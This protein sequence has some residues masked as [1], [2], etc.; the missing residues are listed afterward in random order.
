MTDAG[1]L[2]HVSPKNSPTGIR[3]NLV[4]KLDAAGLNL[5]KGTG[6]AGRLKKVE[7]KHDASLAEFFDALGLDTYDVDDYANAE[8][9]VFT[10]AEDSATEPD[11]VHPAAVD[12][13][14]TAAGKKAPG[15]IGRPPGSK[16]RA[17]EPKKKA[18]NK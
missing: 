2:K 7:L 10:P 11:A 6:G 3:D 18:H 17:K 9:L 12:S 14:A 16:N 1:L 5:Q 8:P 15:K 13:T 4:K